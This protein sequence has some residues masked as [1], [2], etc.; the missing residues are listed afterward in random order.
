MLLSAFNIPVYDGLKPVN[1]P[2]NIVKG[3]TLLE[4][5][6]EHFNVS[7]SLIVGAVELHN[8]ITKLIVTLILRCSR[9]P[10]NIQSSSSNLHI[11]L[12][13]SRS[14]T[15]D[16]QTQPSWVWFLAMFGRIEYYSWGLA[17]EN[18][19]FSS[20][21]SQIIKCSC[22]Q[23]QGHPGWCSLYISMNCQA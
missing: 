13:F 7:F 15:S 20:H 5:D 3:L 4:I 18:T 9:H 19:T 23:G 14:K 22:Y 6:L 8:E 21:S 17:G 10:P 2:G 12:Q 11:I 1:Y 16:Q